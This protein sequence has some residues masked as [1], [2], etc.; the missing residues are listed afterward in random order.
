MQIAAIDWRCA[1]Q[2]AYCMA[3][4]IDFDFFKTGFA[5]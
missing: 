5:M 2:G 1:A 4:G 3:A